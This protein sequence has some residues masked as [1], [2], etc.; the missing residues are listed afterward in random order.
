MQ[1]APFGEW[2]RCTQHGDLRLS[3]VGLVYCLSK[4]APRLVCPR[5]RCRPLEP[6]THQQVVRFDL[7]LGRDDACEAR[8]CEEALAQLGHHARPV[9]SSAVPPGCLD[10]LDEMLLL[11]SC[12]DLLDEIIPITEVIDQLVPSKP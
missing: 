5:P 4:T 7:R 3:K 12:L 8:L 2:H 9:S 11:P 6:L 10:L 1:L